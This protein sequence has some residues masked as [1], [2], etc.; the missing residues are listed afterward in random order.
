MVDI[1]RCQTS[2]SGHAGPV[3]PARQCIEEGC[4]RPVLSRDRCSAHYQRWRKTSDFT[5]LPRAEYRPPVDPVCPWCGP[6]TRPIGQGSTI[7]PTC[8]LDP[9]EHAYIDRILADSTAVYIE[10]VRAY[11]ANQSKGGP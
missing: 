11:R 9:G 2:H 5:V 3:V 4:I 7:C 6:Y 1:V 10:E 8:D